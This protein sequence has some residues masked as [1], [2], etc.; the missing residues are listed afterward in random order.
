MESGQDLK[1]F[2]ITRL[3]QYEDVVSATNP[4]SGI[5][6]VPYDMNGF[7]DTPDGLYNDGF[8]DDNFMMVCGHSPQ[9]PDFIER[10]VRAY[11]N[12]GITV[13]AYLERF[14]KLITWG[15]IDNGKVVEIGKRLGRDELFRE[16]GK[17]VLESPYILTRE[18][19]ERVRG[20]DFANWMGYYFQEHMEDGNDVTAVRCN[21]DSEFDWKFQYPMFIRNLEELGLL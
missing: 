20:D 16:E 13:S 8:L 10:M 9:D 6:V 18:F 7:R 11:M 17:F 14:D 4:F 15:R 3:E 5:E 12:G 19:Y 2:P 1:L 21:T